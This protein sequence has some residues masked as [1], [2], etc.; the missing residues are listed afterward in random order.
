MTA[1]AY[2]AHTADKTKCRRSFVSPLTST[3]VAS[4]IKMIASPASIHMR[5]S[6]QRLD[7]IRCGIRRSVYDRTAREASS[8]SQERVSAEKM[9]WMAKNSVPAAPYS[10]TMA[11]VI[12]CI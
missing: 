1:M 7:N 5:I 12:C 6:G 3:L 9:R 8:T 2:T 4:V 11:A 10:N